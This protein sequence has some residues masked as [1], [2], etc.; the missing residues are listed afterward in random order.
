MY[1][2]SAQRRLIVLRTRCVMDGYIYGSMT[3]PTLLSLPVLK[4]LMTKRGE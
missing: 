4:Q 1:G 3:S 2:I